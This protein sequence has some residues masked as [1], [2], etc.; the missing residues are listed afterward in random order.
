MLFRNIV[1]FWP[2]AHSSPSVALLCYYLPSSQLG[3]KGNWMSN[4]TLRSSTCFEPRRW[5]QGPL[6]T[7]RVSPPCRTS[8]PWSGWPVSKETTWSRLMGR[9][10]PPT[11]SASP[12][13]KSTTSAGWKVGFVLMAMG[14]DDLGVMSNLVSFWM[15]HMVCVVPPICREDLFGRHPQVWQV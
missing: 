7:P 1:T 12:A 4:S 9:S 10:T 14:G 3:F 2:S 8:T 15:V 5:T 13:A 11:V 6:I